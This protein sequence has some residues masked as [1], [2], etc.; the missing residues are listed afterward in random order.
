MVWE[1]YLIMAYDR[2]L[3]TQGINQN[4]RWESQPK[5]GDPIYWSVDSRHGV[6]QGPLDFRFLQGR[7]ILLQLTSRQVALL[8]RNGELTAVFLEG[9]HPLSIGNQPDQVSPDSELIFLAADRPLD[10]TWRTDASLW[11]SNGNES[12]ERIRIR[13]RC[14]CQV[15]GP[16][17]F[18]AAFLR[19]SSNVDEPFTLKVIDVLIRSSIEQTVAKARRFAGAESAEVDVCLA[20]LNPDDLNPILN[21][22]GLEC[23]ALEVQSASADLESSLHTAGQLVAD[24]DNRG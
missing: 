11:I 7:R 18:F 20:R 3:T 2:N 6:V 15:S 22:L 16:A 1:E 13:G 17:Q 8:T 24:R 9:G 10:F 19:H 4:R 14:A 5:D 21:E 12:P 23:T